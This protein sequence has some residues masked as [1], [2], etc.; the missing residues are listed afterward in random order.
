MYQRLLFILSM[1]FISGASMAQ[2]VMTPSDLCF[3][4]DPAAA[5]GTTTN[6]AVPPANVM[7]KWIHDPSQNTRGSDSVGAHGFDQ[8]N[9]KCYIWN[10]MAFRL[11]FPNGYNPANKYPMVLF[12]HGAGEAVNLTR[13]NN[14]VAGGGTIDRENQDQLYWGAQLFEQRMNL[15]DWNGFLLFPQ[16]SSG[17]AQWDHNA[18][19]P[20]VNDI[21]DTL[22]KYNGFDPDRLIVMG[23][24]A[25]GLGAL[26]YASYFPK[27]VATTIPSAP[28]NIKLSNDFIPSFLQIPVWI[29]AGGLD[30]GSNGCDPANMFFIQDNIINAGGNV[31]LTYS[32][33]QGHVMWTTQWNQRDISGKYI[34]SKFWNNAH[35]AQPLVYFQKTSFC[36]GQPISA[37]MGVTAGYYAYEW[38]YDNGGGFVTIGGATS[39]LYTATQAGKYRVHF[40][41][42][43]SS[44]WSDW[45]PNPVV[46]T[47]APCTADTA[48]VEHFDTHRDWTGAA[49]YKPGVYGCQNG[50]VTEATD[51]AGNS[52]SI[53]QDGA[54]VFGGKFMLNSTTT[55]T[56]CVYNAGDQVWRNYLY[57]VNVQPN[58]DYLLNFYMANQNNFY[59]PFSTSQSLA[60]SLT[61]TI[62]DVAV[63]PAGGVKTVG[64]GNTSWKKYSYLWNSG[65]ASNPS[66][67][68]I[69]NTTNPAWNDFVLDEISLVKYKLTMPGAAFKNYTLW[70][71]ANDINA[72]DNTPI[73][74]WTNNDFNGDNLQQPIPGALPVLKNNAADNINFNPV[75]NFSS[76]G[77]YM[78]APIGFSGTSAH[79]AVTAYIVAKFNTIAQ[80]NKAILVEKQAF[81]DAVRVLL[82][83]NGVLTWTAGVDPTQVA[84]TINTVSTPNGAVDVNK[85]IVWSFSKDNNNTASGNKQDIR[86]NGVVIATGN[87]TSSFTGNNL[88]L[89]LSEGGRFFDGSI[90]EVIYL[91]DS[92]V[93]PLKQNKIESYLALKYGTSLGSPSAPVN[94][95]ASDGT[96]IFWPG[97]SI[98]ANAKFQNDVFGIGTDS[99]SGLVQTISNSANS[100]S[101]DGTGQFGKGNL[102][103]ST[104]TTLQDKRF[105]MIGNSGAS[106]AQQVIASGNP[107]IIGS[108][109]VGRNWKVDNTGSVGAVTLSFDTTGLGLQS[110]GSSVNKYALLISNAGDTTY[111]GT[112]SFFNATSGSGKKIIFSGVTLADG[113]TFTIITNN[114]NVALPAVWLG[115]TVEAV[116]GNALL[117]WKTSDEIN[118][119]TYT[120]EHSF[121]GVSFT[122]VGSVAANNNSGV[123]NYNFTHTGLAAGLH[124]YRIRRTDKDGKFE[125]SDIKSVRITTTGANVQVRPNPVVGSTLVLAVSIQ[126]SNKSNVQVAGVDGKVI[127]QQAINLVSGNNMVNINISSVPPG[128]YLVRVQLADEVVTKKFIKER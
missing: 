38:Q 69:N 77:Q 112:V 59:S 90:A 117:K 103:L 3:K 80:D 106:L 115:F 86:K 36:A 32:V 98:A 11:R 56:G 8:S 37:Q 97:A 20:R 73:G 108:T 65:S 50:I 57:P 121:N 67:A 74:L 17:S 1:L 119:A 13:T 82:N 21:M 47:S 126:Q 10:G 96:T 7:A 92:A 24:S 15:G 104:N 70:A 78:Q 128:I 116:S 118:V 34:L 75:V 100:G 79:T 120:V 102:V 127:V 44:P 68:I 53:S 113:A 88:P 41:R 71:K 99:T 49:E 27:R 6:P 40:K 84:T 2:N 14:Q 60:A 51:G 43:S 55:G 35:K 83:A 64:I 52:G 22:E 93:T 62:N 72:T 54:G 26:D 4:Y 46:I 23:L 125:L 89:G 5:V 111:A 85:P 31:Y 109:R 114:V 30:G 45:T 122:S 91:L 33:N 16:L 123:N 76:L 25:G 63:T 110:G 66:L 94:Y 87:N 18:N 124:Y 58:T 61:A 107:L 105:L 9:Y 12:L 39:N 29:G 95:T 42:L 81:T 19:M 28:E 48:F 101:G